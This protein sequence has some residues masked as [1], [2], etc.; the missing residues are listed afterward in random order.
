MHIIDVGSVSDA[1]EE[2]PSET[3]DGVPTHV[4]NLQPAASREAANTGGE[5]AEA[6][7]I[8]LLGALAKKL[9]ADADAENRL[10][11]R[12][13]E[14]IKLPIAQLLHGC[15]CFAHTREQHVC[16]AADDLFIGC[17]DIVRTAKAFQGV[18]DGADVA[19]VVVDDGYHIW[20]I[21]N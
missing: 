1:L 2:W 5:N 15:G 12:G 8:A 18:D 19:G 11:E 4:R 10:R 14:D 21:D 9:C 6:F 20:K 7:G 3:G 13:D 17:E 16:G